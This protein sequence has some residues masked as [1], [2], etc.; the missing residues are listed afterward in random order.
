MKKDLDEFNEMNRNPNGVAFLNLSDLKNKDFTKSNNFLHK[1][2]SNLELTEV[3]IINTL[4]YI[5]SSYSKMY[6]NDE[7]KTN[8]ILN[9]FEQDGFF[10]I[11]YQD[12]LKLLNIDKTTTILEIE[13]RLEN[14]RKTS[15]KYIKYDGDYSRKIGTSFITHYEITKKND[16]TF[17]NVIKETRIKIYF[18][19]ELYQD[20]FN[21]TKIGYTVLNIDINKI[22]SKMGIGLYEE[23]KRI[24]PL[25][26][27]RVKDEKKVVTDK[28]K[29][30]HTYKLDDFNSICGTNYKYISKLIPKL[31][32][33]YKKLVNLKLIDDIYTFTNNNQK[34]E[35]E[36][37]RP[38]FFEDDE[39]YDPYT[40]NKKKNK[41]I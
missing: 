36:I 2:Y 9:N 16:P 23:L 41:I 13:N 32:I 39:Q 20:I 22:A 24:T 18:N 12:L 19:R 25:K 11:K 35:I 5:F 15:Y 34:L 28:F 8:Y 6:K 7:I 38:R 31:L 4:L 37:V 33:Q 17:E 27:I 1:F 10:E 14:I 26:Q 30:I 3:K 21:Y 29:Q 40:L